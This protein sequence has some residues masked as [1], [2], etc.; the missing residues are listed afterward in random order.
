MPYILERRNVR[1]GTKINH[2]TILELP[3]PPSQKALCRCACGEVKWV[4]LTNILGGLSKRCRHCSTRSF[5]T[6]HAGS[7]SR[8]VRR[9]EPLYRAWKAMKWR[10]NPKNEGGRRDYHGRGIRVC[11]AWEHDYPAFRDWSL[12]SGYRAGL[13]L[14]RWPDPKQ[15]ARNTRRNKLLT[16]FGE[17]KPVAE[18]AEDA[19]CGAC[20]WTIRRRVAL[21]WSHA[22][23][24]TSPPKG[25]PPVSPPAP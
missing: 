9:E 14:D 25:K 23:A 21:G 19:R 15:Q 13:S 18:W 6:T 8:G 17:T 1:I 5:A 16:A 7:G 10:C 11:E 22:R 4:A 3:S 20:E 2:W 12:A 24:I